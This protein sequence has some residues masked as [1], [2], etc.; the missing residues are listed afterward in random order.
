MLGELAGGPASDGRTRILSMVASHVHQRVGL[1]CGAV[2][3]VARIGSYHVLPDA[4]RDDPLFAS[5]TLFRPD[6]D[7]R[8]AHG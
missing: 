8:G 7:H 5:R 1:V 6:H 2:E 4:T 3:E